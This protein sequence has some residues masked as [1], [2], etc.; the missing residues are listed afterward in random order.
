[1]HVAEHCDPR[2]CRGL[3]FLRVH[4]NMLLSKRPIRTA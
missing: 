2:L 4:A 1:M 3:S